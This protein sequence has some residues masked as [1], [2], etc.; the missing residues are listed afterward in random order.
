MS[1]VESA[2]RLFPTC[3]TLPKL[4]GMAI[5]AGYELGLQAEDDSYDADVVKIIDVGLLVMKNIDRL[6][7]ESAMKIIA[8]WEKNR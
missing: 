1:V 2:E 3:E 6:L 8:D 5:R 4:V 7:E